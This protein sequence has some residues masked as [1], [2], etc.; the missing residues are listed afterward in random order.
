VITASVRCGAGRVCITGA[1]GFLGGAVARALVKQGA[2]VHVLA[3]HSSDRGSLADVPVTWHNGDVRMP[4]T[5]GAFLEGASEVIH[6]A[7]HLGRVGLRES[8]YQLTNV[9][10]TRNVLT[11]A[12]AVSTRVRVLH[13]STA[14]VLGPTT[15]SGLPAEDAPLAPSNA[16][17]RSKAAA[18]QIAREFA[19]RGLAVII[20]R[21]A[22]VY[23]PGDRHVLGLFRA[24]E[25]GRFFFINGGRCVCHPTFID[26][27]VTGMLQSLSHGRPGEAYHITGI[28]P[29]T[30]RQLAET[31]AAAMGVEA[32]RLSIPRWLASTGAVSL[33]VLSKITGRL[34]ALSRAGVAFFSENRAFSSAKAYRE[35][36]YTPQYQLTKGIERTVAW[37]RQHGWIPDSQ[38]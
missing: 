28:T 30:F 8:D 7:G 14:G 20:A 4:Q 23:G 33:E 26:D 21:P 13:L 25:G 9:E 1:T 18:E 2:D 5:L 16:Y 11:A 12:K 31:I 35:L 22:F 32:P 17:E 36:G 37:Y 34:P 24:I 29:A 15:A 27:A 38:S 3:R 19:A 10:G 6:A